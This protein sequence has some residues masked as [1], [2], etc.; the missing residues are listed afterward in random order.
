MFRKSVVAAAM[1]LISVS[2]QVVA[3]GLGDIDMRSALNQPMDAVIE[4]TSATTTN[5]EDISVSL[6]SLENYGRMGMTKAAI[7]TS[8][9]F[10]VEKDASGQ[11]VI[12][13]SS[14]E[15]VREPYLEFLLE[16][17]WPRG[18]L[19]RQYTVLVDPPVTM[20]AT[21]PVPAAPVSRAATP[22]PAIRAPTAPATASRPVTRPVT[23]PA[24]VSVAPQPASNSYGPIRRSETL[25]SI[26]KRLRPDEGISI[27]Q[28]M[29]ALQRANPQAFEGNNINRLRAGVTMTVPSRDEMV[30][31][32]AREATAESRRQYAEWNAERDRTTSAAASAPQATDTAT[33]ESAEAA[34]SADT[35]PVS[36]AAADTEARLQLTAPE[37]DAVTGAALPGN[38]LTGAAEA[39]VE[40]MQQRLAL[41]AEEVAAEQAQSQELQSRVGELEDQVTTMKRL[42]ELK[43]DE[44]ARLQQSVTVDDAAAVPATESPL[45]EQAEGVV[46]EAAVAEAEPVAA[47][48]VPPAPATLVE[49][50][51][52]YAMGLPGQVT[53]LVKRLMDNPLYAGLGALV[54]LLFGGIIWA[55]RRSRSDDDTLDDALTMKHQLASV[56][57]HES[58][59]PE[60]QVAVEEPYISDSEPA[61][62]VD[63]DIESDPVT[64]AD[65]YLAYG[66][67]QQ[68]ED[69]LL[70]ALQS[71][72][73]NA[74]ARMKLLEVYHSGGNA[75][76]FDQAAAAFHEMFGAD[77]SRWG[78]VATMG[79]A[80]SPHNALYGGGGPAPADEAE[81][82]MDLSGLESDTPP[83]EPSATAAQDSNTIE[84]TLDTAG[85]DEE[86]EG[87]GL[88][89]NVDEMTT[90]L[91]LARAYIDM[92]DADS[93]RS[94]LGEVMEEGNAE[95][96]EEA[97]NIIS[98]L[99]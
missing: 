53:G 55:S 33:T 52:A 79:L 45:A 27:E 16:L 74:E 26:A 43:D 41:A 38:P 76:A 89:E 87:E 91:D 95:Q 34:E 19:L 51:K 50:V 82:D 61:P 99:A 49:T 84:F 20:P 28:V 32:S 63:D 58:F 59:A 23:A 83:S 57:G 85:S 77:D 54:V 44:L 17:D 36:T 42:L 68:A 88:L 7:M 13:I 29:L 96:K 18:R 48:V 2:P 66:R 30:S 4:L 67:I 6:A 56:S 8:F 25:W 24:T 90:K 1:L 21:A 71:H 70:A 94:I 22:A 81:F 40:E 62:V 39:D 69:V 3:L 65:V 31:M 93:A 78:K 73:E 14:D 12:L 72:P 97:E 92:D 80:L 46:G 37:E 11:P 5:L 15:I 35:A 9:R 98:K 47:E 10:S 60:P 75:A 64:E 86:D